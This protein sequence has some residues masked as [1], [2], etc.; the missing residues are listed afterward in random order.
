MILQLLVA[1]CLLLSTVFWCSLLIQFNRQRIKK[2][3]G[4]LESNTQRSLQEFFLFLPATILVRLYLSLCVMAPLM[5]WLLGDWLSALSCFVVVLIAPPVAFK[6]LLKRRYRALQK[7]LPPM[8]VTLS[9]QLRSGISMANGI[10]GLKGEIPA[11][12]GQEVNEVL[13]QVK[14][15]Q[16]LEQALLGWQQRVPIFYS[17]PSLSCSTIGPKITKKF[18][19]KKQVINGNSNLTGASC[20]RFSASLSNCCRICSE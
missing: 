19:G 16:D 3:E 6:W 2:L 20:A 9:N 18:T 13:R 4:T 8:L 5:G 14:L 1:F 17:P 11:P 10:N 15:G 12:L 7:Q